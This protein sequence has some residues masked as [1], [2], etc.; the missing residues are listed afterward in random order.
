MDKQVLAFY[1]DWYSNLEVSGKWGHWDECH[2]ATRDPDKVD[3]KGYRDLGAAHNPQFGPYDSA[4]PKIIEAHI[5][6]AED[7]G[8]DAFAATWWGQRDRRFEGL[9]ERAGDSKVEIALYWETIT[10]G[11]VQGAIDD[12]MWILDNYADKPGYYKVDGRP[13]VFVYRR[14]F[15]QVRRWNEWQEILKAVREKKD[16]LFIADSSALE[17]WQVFDGY[18]TTTSVL[19]VLMNDD[20][21]LFHQL[22][23]QCCRQLGKI[24]AA[25]VIPGFDNARVHEEGRLVTSRKDGRLYQEQWEAVLACEPDWVMINSFNEWHEGSEIEPSLEQGDA[26][27]RESKEWIG[28]FKKNG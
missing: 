20:V 27:L 26:Y 11:T 15:A 24:Y 6:M 23:R 2:Y 3:E 21:Q 18:H 9:L 17:N 16:A 4:D 5:G 10:D 25:P 19:Q 22:M 13:V 7:I 12:I 14:T 8:L 1:Y 28:R